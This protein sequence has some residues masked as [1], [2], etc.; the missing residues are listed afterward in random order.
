MSV[1]LKISVSLKNK[2]HFLIEYD[3]S[4]TQWDSAKIPLIF[5]KIW[6]LCNEKDNI[7]SKEFS[8]ICHDI[9]WRET[10]RRLYD[11]TRIYW[12]KERIIE[13]IILNFNQCKFLEKHIKSRDPLCLQ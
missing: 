9:L 11:I 7:S 12:S 5:P 1:N 10:P 8:F 3:D 4:K 13:Q 6:G 2:K